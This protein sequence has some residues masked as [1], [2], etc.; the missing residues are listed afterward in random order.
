LVVD[1]YIY[2]KYC[3]F[4]GCTVA[5]TL[6]LKLQ[7]FINNWWWEGNTSP[8]IAA[9]GHSHGRACDHKQITAGR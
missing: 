3:K 6:Q 1:A 4:Y 8:M 2:H 7:W 9:K 5:L